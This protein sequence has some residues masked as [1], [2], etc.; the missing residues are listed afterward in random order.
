MK[1]SPIQSRRSV[2]DAATTDPGRR[3]LLRGLV[4]GTLAGASGLALSGPARAVDV[5]PPLPGMLEAM[6]GSCRASGMRLDTTLPVLDPL[7][8][9]KALFD[10][11]VTLIPGIGGPLRILLDL[12]WPS[13][14][15]DITEVIMQRVHALIDTAIRDVVLDDLSDRIGHAG[16]ASQPP[17]GLCGALQV[18]AGH[19]Q[20]Y[21][22]NPTA[23]TRDTLKNA[24]MDLH[25]TFVSQ[26][27]QF[28]PATAPFDDWQQQVLPWF[29]QFANLHLLFLRDLVW[30]GAATGV[31]GKPG[32]GFADDGAGSTMDTFR[33]YFS[34]QRS[35]Y[36]AYATQQLAAIASN[37]ES[38][39]QSKRGDYEDNS[40]W[41]LEEYIMV[42]TGAWSAKKKQNITNSQMVHL[43]QDYRDLWQV[44]D[45]PAGG[46]VRLVRELVYGPYG[47]PDL[48]DL[49]L[50]GDG[51]GN[52]PDVPGLPP[53]PAG[54]LSYL[55]VATGALVRKGKRNFDFPSAVV[56]FRDGD[57][58]SQPPYMSYGV[59]L[60]DAHGGPIV[61][62]VVTSG[63]YAS[64]TSNPFSNFDNTAG[65]LISRLQ[66]T[67]RNGAVSATPGA[68]G[69][70]WEMKG[71][72]DETVDV[73]SGH[74]LSGVYE[75]STVRAFYKGLGFQPTP[76]TY[77]SVGSILFGVRM[78]DP[79]L[80]VT[81]SLLKSVYVTMPAADL[82][83][84]HALLLQSYRQRGA[85]LAAP[86]ASA[87][88]A[89]LEALWER[90][91]WDGQRELF[92]RRLA[93]A[94][95]R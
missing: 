53:S 59:A 30:H 13:D 94:R 48:Q 39:Y 52:P 78:I 16:S 28:A 19:V 50:P 17:T 72:A 40:P 67:Q 85:A 58:I 75:A 65:Y 26:A 23:D 55:A 41:G 91:D 51:S 11:G 21:I 56:T 29:A 63:H 44:M 35:Q 9:I 20:D 86:V 7:N 62:I 83:A 87:W 70:G 74:M 81:P 2:A 60:D 69:T 33:R 77:H 88:L 68:N 76:L 89:R 34:E 47:A 49:G 57:T 80:K 14:Q 71:Y 10:I 31:D 38:Q 92:N 8:D 93:A 12:F 84:V 5:Y 25:Q 79:D 66:F 37:L 32:Y 73:P 18:Y 22:E 95:M 36:S 54:A 64:R 15:P 1:S 61:G 90:W 46:R 42:A 4:A 45:D 27:G 3:E 6:P 43:V 24:A 82:D